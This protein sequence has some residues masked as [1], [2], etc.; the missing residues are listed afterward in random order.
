MLKVSERAAYDR[1]EELRIY[2]RPSWSA[3]EVMWLREESEESRWS[4]GGVP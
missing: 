1:G 3:S 4:H 2:G